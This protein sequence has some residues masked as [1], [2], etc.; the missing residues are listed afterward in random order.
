MAKKK[1]KVEKTA[2]PKPQDVTSLIQQLG[3]ALS[4]LKG[5]RASVLGERIYG[6]ASVDE[7]IRRRAFAVGHEACLRELLTMG[8]NEQ[9]QSKADKLLRNDGWMAE[10]WALSLQL[11]LGL[12]NDL[13]VCLANPAWVDRLRS[14]LVDPADLCGVD[15][16]GLGDQTR[17]VLDAW[18]LVR[19]GDE[20][21]A[22]SRL[23][24]VGRRSPLVDWRLFVQALGLARR[25]DWAGVDS[26]VKRMQNGAPAKAAAEQ[27]LAGRN[28]GEGVYGRQLKR[29]ESAVVVGRLRTTNYSVIEQI[30]KRALAD[31]R[32]G[33]ALSIAASCSHCI[34]RQQDANRYFSLF[35]RMPTEGFSL[36]H[37]YV[38]IAAAEY[39][40]D[41]LLHHDIAEDIRAHKWSVPDGQRLWIRYLMQVRQKWSVLTQDVEAWELEEMQDSLLTPVVGDCHQIVQRHKNCREIYEF[42]N[43]AEMECGKTTQGMRAYVQAFCDD[44]DVLNAAV[45][46]FASAG[47][48]EE[49]E[50]WLDRLTQISKSEA[51]VAE[52]RQT[53]AFHRIRQAYLAG[54]G[55]AVET[56]AAAYVGQS[57]EKR[58]QIALMRWTV[59]SKG[60]KRKRSLE[61]AE[62]NSPWL[63]LY[64]GGVLQIAFNASKLPQSVQ[65]ALE[66][67]PDSVL[68]GYLNLLDVDARSALNI[69][70]V[71]LA[72]LGAALDHP[73]S[74]IALLRRVLSALLM[75]MKHVDDYVFD[76]DGFFSAFGVLFN[77]AADDQAL[78][79]ALRIRMVF[80]A[81]GASGLD[82][83][84]VE[85][86][87]RV[88]WTLAEREETRTLILRVNSMCCGVKNVLLKTPSTEKMM[89]A[90]LKMQQK[91][92]D[93]EQV[94]ARYARTGRYHHSPFGFSNPVGGRDENDELENDLAPDS[95]T[96]SC[97]R[98]CAE[99]DQCPPDHVKPK[100]VMEPIVKPIKRTASKPYVFSKFVPSTELEFV[101]MIEAIQRSSRGTHRE[102]AIQTLTAILEESLFSDKAKA[103][104]KMKIQELLAGE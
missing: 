89:K 86:S 54:E 64:Y 90:E 69:N 92:R 73:Q 19:Q 80:E 8:H 53:V 57:E 4:E 26:A 49:A 102:K 40:R 9:A 60:D 10:F 42:W 96:P 98:N 100:P 61:L 81:L 11:R 84:K 46:R 22:L 7:R 66:N 23:Q 30:V 38:R 1:K 28:K 93:L 27:L 48:C 13:D 36:R 104:L 78:A 52:L 12:V 95:G 45:T 87:L 51:T 3:A 16:G 103:R 67:E 68:Q 101:R 97:D 91:F 31:G 25:N 32:P 21:E 29:L 56:L 79:L 24:G 83:E 71:L 15:A 77:G 41:G 63:V 33:L 62:L 58:I 39:P 99:C 82:A 94:E 17:M 74:S 70:D 47:E 35:E 5:R 18:A 72:A 20:P 50:L 85:H 43:W 37:L 14:E 6:D 76:R 2:T 88:A 44:P 55:K 34:E 75:R 65:R 59:A